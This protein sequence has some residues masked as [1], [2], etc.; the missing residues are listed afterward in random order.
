MEWYEF[1]STTVE[2]PYFFFEVTVLYRW[3]ALPLPNFDS[4]AKISNT[5]LLNTK[6]ILFIAGITP[7]K[8]FW[9][10]FCT[11]LI[12]LSNAFEQHNTQ[13]ASQHR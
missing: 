12:I 11:I 1:K 13:K 8:S 7:P 6:I 4:V 5:V 9:S 3:L 10:L 2:M